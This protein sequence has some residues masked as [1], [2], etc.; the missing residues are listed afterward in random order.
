MI[1]VLS[2]LALAVGL[3]VEFVSAH[4]VVVLAGSASLALALCALAAYRD[5]RRME[6]VRG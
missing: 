5:V 4:L 2:P 3:L 1:V 6:Y